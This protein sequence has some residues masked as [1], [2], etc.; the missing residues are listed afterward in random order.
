M[1]WGGGS[2]L[3]SSNRWK[4]I[5][6]ELFLSMEIFDGIGAFYLPMSFFRDWRNRPRQRRV[7]CAYSPSSGVWRRR[8]RRGRRGRK[9]RGEQTT[10][11]QKHSNH[12]RQK[13]KRNT[14]ARAHTHVAASI[15]TIKHSLCV[16]RAPPA[17]P[18]AHPRAF[19]GRCPGRKQGAPGCR[20][21]QRR[22]DTHAHARAPLAA[23]AA[24]RGR[25]SL[26]PLPP[27]P[28]SPLTS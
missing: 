4:T 8:R 1:Q 24:W 5:E 21:A 12:Q 27:F 2:S 13:Q 11:Q 25:L 28:P 26:A 14:R 23:A 9:F 15:C 18:P 19:A 6:S 10:K 7:V 16:K 20:G 22:T 17:A 3:F